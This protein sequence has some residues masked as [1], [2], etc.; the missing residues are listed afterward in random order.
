MRQK[1]Y[2][3]AETCLEHFSLQNTE[4][5]RKKASIY[6]EKGEYDEAFK[7]LEETLFSLGQSIE[8]TLN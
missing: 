3:E 5:K 4:R 6:V 8:A 1:R 7:V 2:D